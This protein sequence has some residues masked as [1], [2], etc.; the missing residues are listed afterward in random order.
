MCQLVESNNL[1]YRLEI[2]L[3][4]NWRIITYNINGYLECIMTTHPHVRSKQTKQGAT[5][6]K[7]F[8]KSILIGI[9]LTG[10]TLG[11]VAPQPGAKFSGTISVSPQKAK[12]AIILFTISK[13]GTQIS[14]ITLSLLDVQCEG[15]TTEKVDLNV[16][17]DFPIEGKR[18][19]IANEHFGSISGAFNSSTTAGGNIHIVLGK[20]ITNTNASC[21]LGTYLWS[22]SVNN[23]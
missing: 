2:S 16:T 3:I 4:D 6:L 8:L 21:D 19:T 10:C 11:D 17:V 7:R 5:M 20:Y 12:T 15:A 22:A 14:D 9:V 18:F 13:D 1:R 23:E